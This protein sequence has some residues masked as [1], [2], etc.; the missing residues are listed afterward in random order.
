MPLHPEHQPT[1][2]VNSAKPREVLSMHRD[3]PATPTVGLPTLPQPHRSS[4]TRDCCWGR[5]LLVPSRWSPGVH[6]HQLSWFLSSSAQ[7]L[8]PRPTCGCHHARSPWGWAP[9]ADFHCWWW[10]K[11]WALAL[12]PASWGP[13]HRVMKLGWSFP[14]REG[15]QTAA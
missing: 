8:R 1:V 14:T 15:N 7:I 6:Q 5:G 9:V 11:G 12:Q 2:A 3:I 13:S 10:G 4:S